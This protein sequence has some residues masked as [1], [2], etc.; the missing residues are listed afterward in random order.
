[1]CSQLD[2]VLVGIIM[3]ELKTEKVTTLGDA[4]LNWKQIF[5]NKAG[6]FKNGSID[7]VLINV[8]NF[9]ANMQFTHE[10]EKDNKLPSFLILLTGNGEFTETAVYRKPTNYDIFR[11][12]FFCLKHM[13]GY[14]VKVLISCINIIVSISISINIRALISQSTSHHFDNIF[15]H[16]KSIWQTN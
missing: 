1:M 14:S 8:I 5:D 7:T 13:E 15:S 2:P 3:V 12:E 16:Q 6:Y 10:F 9:Y 4:I 11:L